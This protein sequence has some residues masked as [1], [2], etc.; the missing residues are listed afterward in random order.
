MH[1]KIKKLNPEKQALKEQEA[2]HERLLEDTEAFLFHP[3]LQE[4]L[5]ASEAEG[6]ISEDELNELVEVQDDPDAYPSVVARLV[7]KAMNWRNDPKMERHQLKDD[8]LS[9]EFRQVIKDAAAEL[10]MT[11]E[12]PIPDEHY[13][14]AAVLGATVAPVASRTNFLYDS[15]ENGIGNAELL[16]GLG[17]ERPMLAP[18]LRNAETYTYV[19]NSEVE[20]SL[21]SFA[22]QDW[23]DKNGYDTP[24][25]D[26]SSPT[27]SWFKDANYESRFRFQTVNFE[28][29][30]NK[31]DWAPE[32]IVNI[33]APYRRDHHTRANTGETIDFL[34]RTAELQPGDKA[35]FVSHQPYLL[36][37]KFEI[38]RICYENGVEATLAGYGTSNPNLAATVWG[39]EIAK[40]AEKAQQL[41][42][43]LTQES[44][45]LAA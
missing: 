26:L 3:A 44:V 29:G 5:V 43:T 20:T 42:E 4:L 23:F 31:P 6:R 38:E 45:G 9:P 18:D 41:R 37:Q 11:R 28:D 17:A 12:V 15:F 10:G 39:G 32:T 22:A 14:V 1:D 34:C 2:Y 24:S 8:D 40:A 36:G 16:V 19:N 7:H 35:L 21:L 33:S 25:V 27:V 13:K 30:Q